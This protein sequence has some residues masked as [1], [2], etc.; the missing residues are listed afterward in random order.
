MASWITHLRIADA[1]LADKRLSPVH[2]VWGSVAPDSGIAADAEERIFV[3]PKRLSHF[4]RET[5]D[6]TRRID[7]SLFEEKYLSRAG[8]GAPGAEA[9]SFYLGY[10]GHL[11]SDLMWVDFIRGY[12]GPDGMVSPEVKR[13]WYDADRIFLRERPDF[14]AWRIY[15]ETPA[16]DNVYLDIFGREDFMKK[17]REILAF[18]GDGAEPGELKHLDPAKL[19]DFI[20]SAAR[21]VA[22]RINKY[23]D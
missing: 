12:V 16:F 23:L 15:R 2:F 13:E 4:W 8:G 19:E 18:Y 7:P 17:R 5:E 21:V 3:P 22:S 14:E 6:P 20:S 11:I 1:L 10:W 9:K